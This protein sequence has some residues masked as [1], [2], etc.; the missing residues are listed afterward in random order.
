M[1][2]KATRENREREF[3]ASFEDA[4]VAEEYVQIR[5]V[6]YKRSF[7]CSPAKQETFHKSKTFY[8]KQQH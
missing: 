6:S 3:L 5:G 4:K 8:K 2:Q 7:D 1:A